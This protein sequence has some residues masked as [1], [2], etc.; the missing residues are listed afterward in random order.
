[1]IV[2]RAE[3]GPLKF[4]FRNLNLASVQTTGNLDIKFERMLMAVRSNI[5]DP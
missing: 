5:S 2:A 1:M 3:L 4:S